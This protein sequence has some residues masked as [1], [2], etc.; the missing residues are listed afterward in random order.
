MH[1]SSI[2]NSNSLHDS[3]TVSIHQH[4]ASTNASQSNSNDHFSYTDDQK[5]PTLIRTSFLQNLYDNTHSNPQQFH[6]VESF[7]QQHDN[8]V[9]HSKSYKSR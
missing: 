4:N 3:Q 1:S 9:N 7:E 8:A 5:G 2:S 6:H